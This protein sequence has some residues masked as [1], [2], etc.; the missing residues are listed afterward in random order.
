MT[1]DPA[2]SARQARE[3]LGVRLRELRREAGLTGRAVAE[4]V[5]CHFSKVSRIEHGAQTP[6]EQYLR[7][8]CRACSADDQLADLIASVRVI[9]SMY[10]EWRRQT[11]AGMRR[12]MLSPVPL[13][14]RTRLFRIYEHNIIPGLFQTADYA[15]A[16]LKYFIDFLETPNDLEE[17]IRA[18]MERQRILYTGDRRFVVVLEERAMRA[19]VGSIDTMAGQL[20]RLLAVM[21]LQRVSLGI[22]PAHMPR[23][24][25]A[26]LGFWIFDQT[27]VEIETPT[28]GL[29]VTQP[30]EMRLYA[31]MF[32]QLQQLAVYGA[33]ARA[34]IGEALVQIGASA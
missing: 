14:E 29:Q 8:L 23:T 22:I 7:S 26:S 10:V 6:T 17:A 32:E 31:R 34:I 25:F 19:Q 13:Y 18:R 1:T 4:A 20:D 24:V 16:M 11:R 21:S 12:L 33:A 30:R 28:A 9:E 15:T 2:S 27:T 3:A 5:G